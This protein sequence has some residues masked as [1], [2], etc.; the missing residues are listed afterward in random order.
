MDLNK[1]REIHKKYYKDEFSFPDFTNQFINKFQ[2]NDENDKLIV[3]GGIRMIPEIILI[4]D[5]DAPVLDRRTALFTA[6]DYMIYNAQQMN[7]TELHAFVQDH[8]WSKQLK[9]TGFIPIKG[10]GLVLQI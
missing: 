10:D 4:T 1:L 5:K 3:A 8:K 6:L 2:V 9:R 7:L